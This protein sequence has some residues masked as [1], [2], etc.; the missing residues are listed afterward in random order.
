MHV[1]AS[2]PSVTGLLDFCRKNKDIVSTVMMRCGL[3]TCCRTGLHDCDNPAPQETTGHR[4]SSSES[5]SSSGCTNNGGIGGTISGKL[6]DGCRYAIPKLVEMGI[7]PEIWLGE[8]DSISS[9]RYLLSHANST[10]AKMLSVAEANPG[11]AGFQIDLETK[12]KVTS[13]DVSQLKSFLSD[14]TAAMH[15]HPTPLRF[16]ADMGCNAAGEG[17]GPLGSRCHLQSSS[18]VDKLMDMSTYFANDYAGWLASLHS[19]GVQIR[20][21]RT[22]ARART[23][24]SVHCCSEFV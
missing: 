9:A 11:I 2:D 5:R 6:S 4:M 22:R 17:G 8:D 14:V 20:S 23:H 18:G 3:L 15:R 21:A 10:A 12:A 13:V 16:S 1:N 19:A 24:Y 7:R